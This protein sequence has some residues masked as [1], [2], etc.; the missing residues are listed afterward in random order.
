MTLRRLKRCPRLCG[1]KVAVNLQRAAQAILGAN[2]G[3]TGLSKGT[4]LRTMFGGNKW[5]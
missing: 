2:A 4:G 5:V 1:V 3:T